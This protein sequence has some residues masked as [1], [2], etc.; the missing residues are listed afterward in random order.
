M[1]R[2][3]RWWCPGSPTTPCRSARRECAAADQGFLFERRESTALAYR[4]RTTLY[5]QG[6][7]LTLPYEDCVSP[8]EPVDDDQ[9]VKNDV[10]VK[11]EFG[12]SG[13]AADMDSALSVTEIG[14]YADS[15]TL[16]LWRDEAAEQ[17][18][19]WRL[20]LGTWNEA[21]FPVVTVNLARNP[22]L[23]PQATRVEIGDRI[24]ITDPPSWLPP[25]TIDL[26]VTGYSESFAN[27]EWSISYVCVPYGPWQVGA[28]ED[29]AYGWADTS[30]CELAEDLDTTETGIDVTTTTG[31]RWVD[32]ATYPTDFPFDIMVGGELMTVTACTGTTT[33]QTFTVTRS[34]NGIVKTHSTGAD[35]RLTHPA[36]VAL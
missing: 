25:E 18:A 20:H 4:D 9:Q 5:G 7:I 6:P 14:R 1:R 22:E 35:V 21:R 29:D 10:T 8:L 27:K 19:S 13:R 28:V 30:G 24:I 34:V 16:N 31:V 26:M 3:S 2:T 36:Y 15:L 23:I 32:S 33:S 11:R 12:S 17:I